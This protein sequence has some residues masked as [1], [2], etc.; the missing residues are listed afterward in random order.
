M[1]MSWKENGSKLVVPLLMALLGDVSRNVLV[2]T[3][4]N[5]SVHLMR[6]L[7]QTL[8]SLVQHF[9]MITL[10]KVE[11]LTGRAPLYGLNPMAVQ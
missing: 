7:S 5:C 1:L 9:I 11:P 2:H 6:V 4:K 8:W 3:T 10:D